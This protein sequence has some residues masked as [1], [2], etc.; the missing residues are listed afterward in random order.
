VVV[1]E[2]GSENHAISR[3]PDTN[4]GIHQQSAST[5]EWG[6][7]DLAAPC[8]NLTAVPIWSEGSCNRRGRGRGGNRESERREWG[9][10][11]RRAEKRERRELGQGAAR[12]RGKR[13]TNGGS[14][15]VEFVR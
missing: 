11:E 10:K 3:D 6:T 15:V 7:L 1:V 5:A 8:E 12:E 9:D 4:K 13:R 14:I 2:R